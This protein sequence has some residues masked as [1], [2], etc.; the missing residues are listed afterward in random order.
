[1]TIAIERRE[2]V[3]H[4]MPKLRTRVQLMDWTGPQVREATLVNISSGGPLLSTEHLPILNQ[5]IRV[6]LEIAKE[7]GW[8]SAIPVR[9]GQASEIGLRFFRPLPLYFLRNITPVGDYPPG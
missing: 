6:R 4:E 8:V 9:L 2:S 7:I 1:M 3:R 5:P